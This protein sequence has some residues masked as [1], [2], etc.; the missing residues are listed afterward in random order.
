M[1]IASVACIPD[2]QPHTHEKE[3]PLRILHVGATGTVGEAAAA[4]LRA[5]GHEVIGAS[6]SSTELPVDI[7]DPASITALVEK[8]GPVEH[9]ISTAGGVP[10]G[11][12]EELDREAWEA[13]L[14]NKLLGQV[15]V[16]RRA[17]STLAPGG[18][19]TLISGILAREPIRGGSIAAAVN[20][21]LEAWVK[22]TS[23]E[24]A[25][26]FRI[27]IVS[28]T[29]LTESVEKYSAAMPG[30]PQ[31]DGAAVGAAYVRSVES[32]ETG[33]VYIL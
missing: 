10:F 6:R 15:E 20:G 24:M 21:A 31:V 32:F 1:P 9:V 12:W 28:P 7:T 18:S 19:F 3:F 22:A 14:G 8:V 29:V 30:F 23:L 13:G 17:R 26:A 16:V 11:A 33:Q 5:R 25:G 4:A 2:R 27:N